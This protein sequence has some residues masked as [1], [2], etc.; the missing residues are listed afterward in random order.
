[1]TV[2]KNEH[3]KHEEFGPPSKYFAFLEVEL[4]WIHA[5]TNPD[6]PISHLKRVKKAVFSVFKWEWEDSRKRTMQKAV[7]KRKAGIFREW[8][9]F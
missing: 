6:I 2:A 4:V 1:M 9:I 8:K 5:M 3:W 7:K